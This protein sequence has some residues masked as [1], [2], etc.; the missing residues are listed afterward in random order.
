MRLAH[1]APLLLLLASAQLSAT[2]CLNLGGRTTYVQ[3]AP[4]TTARLTALETR[5]TALEAAFSTTASASA[6]GYGALPQP[7][8]SDVSSP[9]P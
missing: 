2:G 6:G 1:R 9:Q 3:E 7:V 4:E 8:Y 5:V